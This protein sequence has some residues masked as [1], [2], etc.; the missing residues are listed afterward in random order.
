MNFSKVDSKAGA[1]VVYGKLD[2]ILSLIIVGSKRN[3]GRN[4]WIK[5]L[6]PNA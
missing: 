3:A 4:Y 2:D 6:A 5:K 1:G